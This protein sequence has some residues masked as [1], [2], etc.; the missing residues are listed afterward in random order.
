MYSQQSSTTF[1]AIET[2]G[3]V[4]FSAKDV[5]LPAGEIWMAIARE[6]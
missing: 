2:L 6:L 4:G 3:R 5:Q 1:I